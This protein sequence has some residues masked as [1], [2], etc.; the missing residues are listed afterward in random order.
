[1]TYMKLQLRIIGYKDMKRIVMMVL[2]L[3]LFSIYYFVLLC[4][5]S[6][7]RV[8]DFNKNYQLISKMTA[9]V[10]KAGKVKIE[11]SG[12]ENLPRE[13]GFVL[14]PNHQGLYDTLAFFESCP[15]TLSFVIK[16]E[17]SN[18]ILLKQVVKATGS[19]IM[20]R[21]DI[22]QSMEII[23]IM[24]EEVKKGRNFVIFPEGTRS[25]QGNKLIDF[26]PGS[27]KSAVKAKA[28]IVP[29]AIMNAYIPFD[30]NHTKPVT[31]KLFYLK[32]MYYDEYKNMKTTEIA[33]EVKQRIEKTINNNI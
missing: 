16:K 27:F 14:F 7:A 19:L 12:I 29:C 11:A 8:K 30:E 24:T 33:A 28:P 13:N 10:N 22:R 23:N 18:V 26:K 21:E 3:G 32:P 2:R 6:N 1:M 17:A 31:V 20:D 15:R 25:K 5:K 9:R 4:I